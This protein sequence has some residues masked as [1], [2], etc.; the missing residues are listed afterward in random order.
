[1]SANDSGERA[2]CMEWYCWRLAYSL[3]LGPLRPNASI[4]AHGHRFVLDEMRGPPWPD[5]ANPPTA[6]SGAPYEKEDSGGR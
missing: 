1:M 5:L 3:L 6:S 4:C 2:P